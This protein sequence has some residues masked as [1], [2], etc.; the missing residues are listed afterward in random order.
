MG[1]IAWIVFGLIAGFLAVDVFGT[2]ELPW[3][4]SAPAS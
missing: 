2:G 1:I 3:M 4:C